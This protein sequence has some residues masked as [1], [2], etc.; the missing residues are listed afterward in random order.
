MR[1]SYHTGPRVVD[2]DS[3]KRGGQHGL[4]IQDRPLGLVGSRRCLLREE[5]FTKKFT[6]RTWWPT[7]RI[8][9]FVLFKLM[10]IRHCS[11]YFYK[12]E[13]ISSLEGSIVTI[14]I[15]QARTWRCT[16]SLGPCLNLK[17]HIVQLR[18]EG[19]ESWK[20]LCKAQEKEEGFRRAV[21]RISAQ[22]FLSRTSCPLLK[23]KIWETRG[24]FFDV[25]SGPLCLH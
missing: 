17:K 2:A 22:S 21:S 5:V 24:S 18:H 14:P 9:I 11:G 16:E 8:D 13:A 10:W 23:C 6:V 7:I 25:F 12:Y 15:L 3:K 20:Y 4:M 19:P 1:R